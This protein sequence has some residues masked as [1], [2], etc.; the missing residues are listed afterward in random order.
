MERPAVK[1]VFPFLWTWSISRILSSLPVADKDDHLSGSLVASGLERR[2]P[3]TCFACSGE[4]FVAKCF[5]PG[6]RPCTQ[7][8]IL[9]LHTIHYCTARPSLSLGTNFFFRRNSSLF[10]PRG[11]LRA[12][13]TRY[14]AALYGRVFGLSSLRLCRGRSSNQG[15]SILYHILKWGKAIFTRVR[16]RV[17]CL[18]YSLV[19]FLCLRKTHPYPYPHASHLRQLQFS[20]YLQHLF[21]PQSFLSLGYCSRFSRRRFLFLR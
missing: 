1:R 20:P 12:G 7:V 15:P 5:S 3:K 2:F 19:V 4:H 16:Y 6:T 21:L 18:Y 11:L 10:A 8:R 17:Y 14:L 9:P 13:V